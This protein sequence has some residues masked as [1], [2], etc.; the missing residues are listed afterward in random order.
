MRYGHDA[1]EILEEYS[2]SYSDMDVESVA[3]ELQ[4][5]AVGAIERAYEWL[6][7]RGY[8]NIEEYRINNVKNTML[9]QLGLKDKNEQ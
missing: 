2:E 3:N 6:H 4:R 7:D 1:I 8:L 9:E 5:I